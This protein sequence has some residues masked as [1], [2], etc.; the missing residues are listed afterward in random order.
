MVGQPINHRISCNLLPLHAQ[1]I[2]WSKCS[3]KF[4][5]ARGL[6]I[7]HFQTDIV[8]DF[9]SLTWLLT[10]AVFVSEYEKTEKIEENEFL[11]LQ[12]FLEGSNSHNS[13]KMAK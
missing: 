2:S 7:S 13:A 10:I 11:L 5:K 4:W 1:I 12:P 6:N 9:S 8:L 3:R